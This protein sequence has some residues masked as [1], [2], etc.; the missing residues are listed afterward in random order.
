MIRLGEFGRATAE[1]LIRGMRAEVLD[2]SQV[3]SYLRVN[4]GALDE[5]EE[6]LTN[7]AAVETE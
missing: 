7:S 4:D 1:T 3:A 5:I 2:R 6:K